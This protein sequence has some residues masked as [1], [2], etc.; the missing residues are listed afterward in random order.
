MAKARTFRPQ[1]E[2]LAQPPN[3]ILLRERD[4]D[5]QHD[6]DERDASD[7]SRGPL[8]ESGRTMSDSSDEEV[9]EAVAE[10]IQRFEDSFKGITARYRLINRIG[11]GPAPPLAGFMQVPELTP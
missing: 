6:D 4:D 5:A 2:Q 3:N 8:E 1:V 10:D 7:E 11:E 9:E